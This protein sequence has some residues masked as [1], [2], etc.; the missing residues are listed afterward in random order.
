MAEKVSNIHEYSGYSQKKYDGYQVKSQYLT[1]HDGVKVA[2]DVYRPTKNGVL[3][4][5]KLPVIWT[6]TQYRRAIIEANG[7]RTALND[8]LWFAPGDIE[9]IL[10]YGY[11]VAALDVR[12]SGASYGN[13]SML[14]T[15]DECYDLYDVNEWLASQEW[16]SGK[17]GMFGCSYLACTQVSAAM[18]APPSLKCII[19]NGF[20]WEIPQMCVNGILNTSQYMY[21]DP[22]MYDKSVVHPAVAVD[23]DVDGSMLAE[24]VEI[25]KNNPSSYKERCDSPYADSYIEATHSKVYQESYLPKYLNNLNNSGIAIYVWGSWK[26]LASSAEQITLYQNYKGPKRAVMGNWFHPGYFIPDAPN[27]TVEHLRWYDYWLK[28]IDNGIMNEP[29]MTLCNTINTTETEYDMDTRH[30]GRL[31]DAIMIREKHEWQRAYQWPSPNMKYEDY[32]FLG[33]KS[34][35]VKSL[36]DGTLSKREPDEVEGKDEY[37]V[38]Y[39]ITKIGLV[40]RMSYGKP[41]KLDYTEFDEKSITYTT[42]PLPE[43]IQVSGF[44]KVDLW[45]AVD[46]KNIDFYV[47]LEEIDENGVSHFLTDGKCRGSV[48][49]TLEPPYDNFGMPYHRNCERDHIDLPINIPVKVEFALTPMMNTIKSGKRI[50]VTINN[51]DKDRW[52]TPELNPAPKVTIFR[53]TDHTSCLHLPIVR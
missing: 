49:K 30:I 2:I 46:A 43:D 21:M 10:Q 47:T 42:N 14:I 24:A 26:D 53:S 39:S 16:C 1:M 50:R 12:G 6:A 51:C 3:H 9:T 22:T 52:D 8:N 23:E 7:K 15:L 48:R 28:G 19:P 29:P 13:R 18:M 27:W 4:E 20:S 34:D 40:D 11:V 31:S 38:D 32:F 25:H 37:T 45:F 5:E 41:G 36:N 44:P 17:T 35:T 33:K